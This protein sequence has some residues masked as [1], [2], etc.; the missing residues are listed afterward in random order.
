RHVARGPP[1][2]DDHRDL[3][4]GRSRCGRDERARPEPRGARR[5]RRR[6][7]ARV[8][9]RV[10]ADIGRRRGARV[11]HGNSILLTRRSYTLGYRPATTIAGPT[12]LKGPRLTTLQAIVLGLTQG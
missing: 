2:S 6:R 4:R 9:T 3:R 1:G 12:R 5:P 11:R 7:T 8:R 10:C